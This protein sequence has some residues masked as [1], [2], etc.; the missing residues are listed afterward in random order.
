MQKG[1]ITSYTLH[2][3]HILS[4]SHIL[5]FFFLNLSLNVYLNSSISENRLV[6]CVVNLSLFDNKIDFLVSF[7][8]SFKSIQ[9]TTIAYRHKTKTTVIGWF[10]FLFCGY[11]IYKQVIPHEHKQGTKRKG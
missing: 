7:C 10:E 9:Q 2:K 11:D 8:K 6:P 5:L 3:Q 4:S 1:N